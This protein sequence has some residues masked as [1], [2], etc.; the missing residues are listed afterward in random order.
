M[1]CLCDAPGERML[2]LQKQVES[3]GGAFHAIQG[4]FQLASLVR[5]DDELVMLQDGLIPDRE[6]VLGGTMDEDVLK[7]GILTIPAGHALPDAFPDDFERIDRERSWAG[8]AVMRATEVH[9]IADFPPD[10]AAIPL[11]LRLGL[12]AHVECREV[13]ADALEDGRWMLTSSE[14][15][16]V[17]RENA[18]IDAVASVPA[19]FGPLQAAAALIVRRSGSQFIE[20]GRE[21][22]ALAA[23]SLMLCAVL[24]TGFGVGVAGLVVAG[25]GSFA[26]A[27]SGAWQRLRGSLWT[28]DQGL[29][30]G[31]ALDIGVDLFSVAA[32]ALT[33]GLAWN[34]APQ[35]ALAPLAIGLARL[36]SKGEGDGPAAFWRD[37]PLHLFAFAAAAAAGLLGEA[38]ALFS[39]AALVQ[40][41]LR[42]REI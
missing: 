39:L 17:E 33:Y 10:S 14:D 22:S 4:N 12:Q 20:K 25:M 40:L 7:R 9:K 35:L 37:R 6:T 2:G 8:V 21:F 27:L 38:L 29:Q 15:A 19:W 26:A 28:T 42:G 34:A 13:P 18:L 31:T 36:A 3:A 30:T 16:L 41:M 23:V 11:L 24:L 1:I 5:A 32:L